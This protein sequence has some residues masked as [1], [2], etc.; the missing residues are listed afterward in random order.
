MLKTLRLFRPLNL[1][2][3]AAI[4]LV[5]QYL[6]IHEW[7][8]DAVL[9]STKSVVLVVIITAIAGAA[10]YVINDIFDVDIDR[11]NK[12]GRNV[13]G[14]IISVRSAWAIYGLLISA[15]AILT[16]ML[17]EPYRLPGLG[18]YIL[19]TIVLYSYSSY[20]KKTFIVGNII[21]SVFASMVIYVLWMGQD[22]MWQGSQDNTGAY[23]IVVM[24]SLFAFGSTLIREIVKDIEDMKGDATAGA[25]T[26]PN[27]AGITIA[28]RIC[29]AL[30]LLFGAGLIVW[31]AM[32]APQLTKTAKWYFILLVITPVLGIALLAFINQTRKQWHITSQYIKGVIFL[33]TG[34]LL[35]I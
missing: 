15:G 8:E 1:Y 4:Q 26:L 22:L 7:T 5:I 12:P 20:F 28:R 30:A 2:L 27:V 25:R 9:F 13:V 17:G 21:V 32:I 19:T 23:D 16:W 3:I 33:G 31:L 14:D 29:I 18:F 11:H 24:Y 34:F 35:L 6:V 10:G